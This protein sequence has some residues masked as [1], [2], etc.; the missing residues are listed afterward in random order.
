M[1]R[2]R[3]VSLA[4]ALLALGAAPAAAGGKPDRFQEPAPPLVVPGGPDGACEFDVEFSN[5]VD[6]SMTFIF[7][8]DTNGD[9]RLMVVGHVVLQATNLE[10]GESVL[11]PNNGQLRIWFNA[12]GS[13]EAAGNGQIMLWYLATDAPVSS[14]GQ[15][16]WYLRGHATEMYDAGG[17]L[18]SASATGSLQ[19]VCALLAS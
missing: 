1:R 8:A 2:A 16:I 14:V 12:D 3:S 11:F 15:G 5:T 10:T 7:P 6:Q 17:N 9:Q 18:L 4:L 13:V 19:D